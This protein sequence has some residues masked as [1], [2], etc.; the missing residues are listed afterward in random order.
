MAWAA[1][2]LI[3]EGI[4]D[5]DAAVHIVSQLLRTL[6]APQVQ[7]SLNRSPARIKPSKP[8]L[9]S[10]FVGAEVFSQSNSHCAV[11]ATAWGEFRARQMQG[12]DKPG[13]NRP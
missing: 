13:D 4:L 2:E 6:T 5:F 12:L 10:D 7:T 3:E 1:S 8:Y 9:D 11:A